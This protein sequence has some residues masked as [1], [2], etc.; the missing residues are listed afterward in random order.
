MKSYL[1]EFEMKAAWG[2][3]DYTH[4]CTLKIKLGKDI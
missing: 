3:E 4:C 1:S 2:K